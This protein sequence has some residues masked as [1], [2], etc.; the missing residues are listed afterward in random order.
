MEESGSGM[1]QNN[2]KELKFYV[3]QSKFHSL[4]KEPDRIT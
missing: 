4:A 1:K 2:V 3:I